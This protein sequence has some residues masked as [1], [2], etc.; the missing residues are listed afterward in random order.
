MN[1]TSPTKSII[2]PD[3]QASLIQPSDERTKQHLAALGVQCIVAAID[4]P[5]NLIA[6]QDLLTSEMFV[7]AAAGLVWSILLDNVGQQNNSALLFDEAARRLNTRY[8]DD[9]RK[10][11]DWIDRV[12]ALMGQVNYQM[13]QAGRVPIDERTATQLATQAREGYMRLMIIATANGISST[14]A[15]AG[16]DVSDT[17]AGAIGKLTALG[18][19]IQN[20]KSPAQ[21]VAD[22]ALYLNE[23]RQGK[24]APMLTGIPSFDAATGGIVPGTVNLLIGGGG[25]GKTTLATQVLANMLASGKRAY[26]A[27]MEMG[28]NQIMLRIASI[29][30]NVFQSKMLSGQ[31]SE[32]DDNL[33]MDFIEKL[34][35]M[36][37]ELSY[38]ARD[39]S[40]TIVSSIK[41][42]HATSPLDLIFI[43]GLTYI[44]VSPHNPHHKP[45][46]KSNVP[47][48][49][50]T[51]KDC[52]E[53]LGVPIF[54]LHHYNADYVSG[55]PTLRHIM[56][57]QQNQ[58]IANTIWAMERD[59]DVTRLHV[60]KNRERGELGVYELVWE[61]T[62]YG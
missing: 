27:S 23:L 44:P 57:G 45:D 58:V 54:I 2:T 21:V 49:L 37:H 26:F 1:T 36:R 15:V 20:R 55:T 62:R 50:L 52:A 40:A 53:E 10:R 43:D 17:L 18:L 31:L 6:M 41:I 51:F 7:D 47:E 9:A 5:T 24:H 30:T 12:N 13:S 61:G 11:D 8:Q 60:L 56:G 59:G 35:Q 39:S 38:H 48:A 34:T 4:A 33:L 46:A 19:A 3:F 25:K 29:A 14:A 32:Y 16:S 28:I 42:A 22:F